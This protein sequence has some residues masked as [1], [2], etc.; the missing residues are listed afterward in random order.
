MYSQK[1]TVRRTLVVVLLVEG[2]INEESHSVDCMMVVV[3]V[4][5][6]DMDLVDSISWIC[7]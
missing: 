6:V 7:R 2:D 1:H 3:L 5:Q 4:V